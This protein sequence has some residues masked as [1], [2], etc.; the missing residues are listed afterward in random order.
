MGS[1]LLELVRSR[2]KELG[3]SY[4]SLAA[5]CVDPSS[6]TTA[7]SAWLHRLE[8]SA[9]VIPPSVEVLGALAA[10]LQLPLAMLQEAAAAQF[11]DLRVPWEMSDE[12]ADLLADVAALPKAQREALTALIKVMAEGR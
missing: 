11:F 2:R 3:L 4:Q 9:P 5:A 8:T 6:G 1:E 10:G 7:S 12:A